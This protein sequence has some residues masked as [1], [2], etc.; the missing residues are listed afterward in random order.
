[1]P[2]KT[3]NTF[4]P[5][6]TKS[7]AS[8]QGTEVYQAAFQHLQAAYDTLKVRGATFLTPPFDWGAEVRCFFRDPDGHLLEISEAKV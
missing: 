7:A 1:M 6:G 2:V 8:S 5:W 4:G 3:E